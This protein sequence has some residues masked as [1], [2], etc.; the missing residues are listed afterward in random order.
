MKRIKEFVKANKN[1][2]V[3]GVLTGVAA[4]I[5]T[6]VW[7]SKRTEKYGK[8]DG[9]ITEC[10]RLDGK[11]PNADLSMSELLHLLL[12][13]TCATW[14]AEGY[15]NTATVKDVLSD[16]EIAVFEECGHNPDDVINGFMVFTREIKKKD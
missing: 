6:S 1:V 3:A 2:I 4:V 9:L 15:G 14:A 5:G 11:S 16:I 7:W 10:E 8:Y 12:K 13:D